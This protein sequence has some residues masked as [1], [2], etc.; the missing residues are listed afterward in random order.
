LISVPEEKRPEAWKSAV[1][2]AG[3]GPLTAKIVHEAALKFK[4][5]KSKP[6]G[7]GQNK[8]KKPNPVK[9]I[10]LG[11]AMK[12]L[13]EAAGLAAG[14]DRLLDKLKAVREWLQELAAKM[15]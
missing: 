11:P 1:R 12:L 8:I 7:K 2:L 5:R 4:P 9:P 13:D 14:N 10:N 6:A 15:A 3:D